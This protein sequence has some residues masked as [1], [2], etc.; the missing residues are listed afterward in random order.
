MRNLNEYNQE[1]FKSEFEN[2]DIAKNIAAD[3]DTLIWE[4][5]FD[6]V[7]EMPTPRQRLGTKLFPM[8]S[9]YYIQKLL[10]ANPEKII[11]IG[12]GWNVHKKY[13]PS[14]VGLSPD[15]NPKYYFGD[16]RD[17]FDEDFVQYN[18]NQ[19][20]SV[21]SI[22]ALNYKPLTEIKSIVTQFISIVKPGGR[23]FIALDLHPMLDVED[24]EVLEK[25][26]GTEDPIDPEVEDYVRAQLKDL[27]CKVLV[28]D[29]DCPE[30]NDDVDGHLRIVFEKE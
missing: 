24:P 16:N 4:K 22:C 26:F 9:F 30:V 23:G 5:H 11:D 20:E 6:S 27:P 7:V 17:Y 13:I 21:M 2:S 10:E 25:V 14:I 3:F 18:T 29:L 8:S 1:N 15:E 12:C 19:F 28:F